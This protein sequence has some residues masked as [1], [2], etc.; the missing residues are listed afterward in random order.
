MCHNFLLKS[1]LQKELF[2]KDCILNWNYF[3]T[4]KCYPYKFCMHCLTIVIIYHFQESLHLTFFI[5]LLPFRSFLTFSLPS[6]FLTSPSNQSSYSSPPSSES[7][8]PNSF[9][10]PRF[11]H[12]PQ[13]TIFTPSNHRK[14][15]PINY[16][17]NRPLK[18]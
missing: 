12:R 8:P 5:F 14:Y 2:S 17:K 4:L 10:N 1:C 3:V 9:F 7:T 18:V 11:R 13:N 16:E 6:T 15:N